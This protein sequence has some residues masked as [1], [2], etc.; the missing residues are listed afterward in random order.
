VEVWIKGMDQRIRKLE[1][2]RGGRDGRGIWNM[3]GCKEY[4]EGI[5]KI[6]VREGARGLEREK[7]WRER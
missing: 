6:L 4:K 7:I 1:G 2:E 3:E 5:E